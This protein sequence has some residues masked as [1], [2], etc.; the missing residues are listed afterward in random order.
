MHASDS[1]FLLVCLK[2]C[3]LTFSSVYTRA[4]AIRNKGASRSS[5]TQ[6]GY[7]IGVRRGLT[8]TSEIIFRATALLDMDTLT[9]IDVPTPITNV[10]VAQ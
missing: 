8:Q 2:K 9:D 4:A 3:L 7:L 5:H 10:S 6:T 1:Y